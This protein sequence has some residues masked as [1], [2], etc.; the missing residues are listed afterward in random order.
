MKKLLAFVVLSFILAGIAV[1]NAAIA[2]SEVGCTP[3]SMATAVLPQTSSGPVEVGLGF[4]FT[5]VLGVSDA[6]QNIDVDVAMIMEWTD[7]RLVGYGGCFLP[8]TS[9]WT[10]RASLLNSSRLTAKY[11]QARDRVQVLDNGRVRYIQR[12]SGIISTY[13][14]LSYFPFDRQDFEFRMITPLYASDQVQF[15]PIDKDIGIANRLNIEDWEFGEVTAKVTD[16]SLP[17][18]D[19]PHSMMTVTLHAERGILFYLFKVLVP[20]LLIVSM[21]WVVF[22]IPPSK[23]EAQI[24]FGA[25]SMLT[26]IAFQFGL[27]NS[28]PKLT[29]FTSMDYLVIGATVLVYAAMFEALCTAM[30]FRRGHEDRAKMIERKSRWLFPLLL[31]I[32]W[33]IIV[34]RS[35]W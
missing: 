25:T 23:F 16:E 22:W 19:L 6:D 11:V 15:V 18:Y 24:G 2:Q 7:P 10:P 5:D 21:S 1:P 26:L 28:V 17:T 30:I 32:Y 20:L 34:L 12:Y 13:H 29:Y 8:F 4:F 27:V 33:G 35:V 31:V 3:P 9:V 14:D